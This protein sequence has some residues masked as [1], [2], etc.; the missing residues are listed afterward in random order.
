MT[1]PALKP[2]NYVMQLGQYRGQSI[3]TVRTA[4]LLWWLSQDPLRMKYTACSRVIAAELRKRFAVP[5]GIE[6]ELIFDDLI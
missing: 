1:I 4:Y 3:E 2:S 5:E 6:T